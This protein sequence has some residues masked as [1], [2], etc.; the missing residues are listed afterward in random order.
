LA[1]CHEQSKKARGRQQDNGR[2]RGTGIVAR[3]GLRR[4]D[5]SDEPVA[6]AAD[7]DD[8]LPADGVELAAQAA[9]VAVEGPGAA[10]S[11][12]APYRA[13]QLGRTKDAPGIAGEVDEQ[14][15]F[16]AAEVEASA[17]ERG[18]VG[19]GVD[20]QRADLYDPSV[21]RARGAAKDGP[22]AGAQLQVARRVGHDVVGTGL[23]GPQ[24]VGLLDV[25][26][27]HDDRHVLLPGGVRAAAADRAQQRESAVERAKCAEHHE[28]RG[29]LAGEDGGV[30]SAA[31]ERGG[32]LVG[33][34]LLDDGLAEV[35][36]GLD[37]EDRLALWHRGRRPGLSQGFSTSMA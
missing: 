22:Q 4:L 33:D 27:E 30:A 26:A 15:V 5:G 31:G 12:V 23:E 24:E 36:V 11:W 13:Q 7:V 8:P 2:V 34:Q 37:D 25:R 10:G 29:F 9:G 17:V 14:L 6:D 32:M 28:R 35:A 3:R 21:P 20:R 19:G 1:V 16:H 18:G